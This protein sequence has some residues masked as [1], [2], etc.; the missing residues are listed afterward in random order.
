MKTEKEI[1]D[2]IKE[3]EVERDLLASRYGMGHTGMDGEINMLLWVVD[4]C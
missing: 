2:K 1:R 3:L 4:G